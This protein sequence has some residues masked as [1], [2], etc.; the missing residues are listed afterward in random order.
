MVRRVHMPTRRANTSRA[1]RN[2][3]AFVDAA[4]VA[5]PASSKVLVASAGNDGDVDLTILR[6]HGIFIATRDDPTGD[7]FISGAFGMMVVTD[8][9][10]AA[11]VASLPGPA[12]NAEDDGWIVHQYFMSKLHFGTDVSL[13]YDAGQQVRFDSKAKRIL[14]QDRTFVAVVE[15]FTPVAIEFAVSFRCLEMVRG[16]G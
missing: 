10:A 9:A 16:T 12:T 7:Q 2:W 11:G 15:N 14:S 6:T 3:S 8:L 13:N 4:V 1:N 5:V